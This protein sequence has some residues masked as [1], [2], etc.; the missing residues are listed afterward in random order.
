MTE[1]LE[2]ETEAE[3]ELVGTVE[4]ARLLHCHPRILGRFAELCPVLVD[5][6]RKYPRTN[7]VAVAA[8]RGYGATGEAIVRSDASHTTRPSKRRRTDRSVCVVDFADSTCPHS[9]NRKRDPSRCSSCLELAGVEFPIRK[10][11][12]S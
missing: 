8:L 7:V 4:A 2:V 3:L 10:H 9:T 1:P 6:V 5:G 11:V 12:R